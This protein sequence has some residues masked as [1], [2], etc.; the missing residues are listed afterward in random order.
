MIYEHLGDNRSGKTF[1]N[2]LFAWEAYNLGRTVYCNCGKD[3]QGRSMHILNFPH[4]H[5]QFEKLREMDLYECYVMSDES[6]EFMDAFDAPKRMMREIGYFGY[7]ATKRGV[8]WHYD[9]V[10]HKN[11]YNRVRLN[12]HYYIQSVRYPHNP[13]LPIQAIKLIIVS[14]YSAQAKTVWMRQPVLGTFFPIY[15]HVVL[16]PPKE[17]AN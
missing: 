7:Q 9:A 11:I 2:A 4:R 12:P 16:V 3:T 5:Y 13:K 8:D 1:T 17:N 14:R 6:V 10:R 15:N